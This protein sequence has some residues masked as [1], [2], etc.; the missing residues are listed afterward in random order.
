[1]SADEFQ[2]AQ[3]AGMQAQAFNEPE[4]RLQTLRWDASCRLVPSRFPPVSLYERVADPA[5]LAAVFAIETMTNPRCRQELGEL[6]LV[7][8]A[9]RV[10][11]PGT[12]PIMAAFTHL[13]PEGSRFSDGSH[14]VYYAASDLPTAIAEVSHHRAVFLAHTRE[15]AIELDVR[16]YVGTVQAVL[17]DIRGER[18]A[19]AEVYR[20]QDYGPSQAF[21]RRM[22]AEGRWGIVYE[23]VRREGGECVALFKPAAIVPPVRQGE[24]L[25]IVWDGTRISGWYLK[26]EHHLLQQAGDAGRTG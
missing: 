21:A 22:R 18:E 1:M 14:G 16:N 20:P 8:E 3:P 13:N 10:S 2:A 7:P 19:R 26:S 9:E 4:L 15:P 24:H 25:S 11:G 23:S 12:T 5:D 6:N 17:A